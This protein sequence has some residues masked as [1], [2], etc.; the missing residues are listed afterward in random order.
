M[1]KIIFCTAMLLGITHFAKAQ[2]TGN[3]NSNQGTKV[4]NTDKNEEKVESQAGN[5]QTKKPINNRKVYKSKKTGQTATPTG[6]EATGTNGTHANNP[7]N[8]AQKEE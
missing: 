1:K 3:Q 4:L 2:N 7:K 5:Q 8:A 6:Q